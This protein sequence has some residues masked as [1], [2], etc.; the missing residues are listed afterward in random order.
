LNE[1]TSSLNSHSFG[2]HISGNRSTSHHT[3]NTYSLSLHFQSLSAD[4]TDNN[5]SSLLNMPS[6]RV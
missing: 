2:S 5:T 1:E 4:M 3:N 6:L